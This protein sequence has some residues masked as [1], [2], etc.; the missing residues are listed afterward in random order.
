VKSAIR[1]GSARYLDVGT[2]IEQCIKYFNVIAAGSPVQRC[3][4]PS[5]RCGGVG[6]ATRSTLGTKIVALAFLAAPAGAQ[7]RWRPE[8]YPSTERRGPDLGQGSRRATPWWYV[9]ASKW[10]Q[11]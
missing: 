11:L 10:R 7:V 9:L 3:L 1:D 6:V 5:S 4:R 2:A 8:S